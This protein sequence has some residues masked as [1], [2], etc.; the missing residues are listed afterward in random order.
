MKPISV[1]VSEDDYEELKSMAA[2]TGRPVAELIRRAM[3]EYLDRE[4]SG[5]RSLLDLPGHDSGR[6]RKAWT[7]SELADEMRER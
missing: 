2:R 1:H 5:R 7:R 6:L 3:A 4:R